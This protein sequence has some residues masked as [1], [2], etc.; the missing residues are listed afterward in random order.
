[1]PL[2]AL[3]KSLEKHGDAGVG[4]SGRVHLRDCQVYQV[5]TLP[6][7]S[8]ELRTTASR[9]LTL[10]SWPILANPRMATPS[11]DTNWLDVMLREIK[12]SNPVQPSKV[13]FFERRFLYRRCSS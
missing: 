1:M 4:V 9:S 2:R 5:W 8:S 3:P 6:R 10:R 11:Q 12:C 13:C 7:I